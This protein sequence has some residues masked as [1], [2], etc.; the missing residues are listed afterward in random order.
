LSCLILRLGQDR[1]MMLSSTIKED[2]DLLAVD[3]TNPDIHVE[4]RLVIPRG[5]LHL[6]RTIFLWKGVCYERFQFRNYG[7][8]PIHTSFSLHFEA[9]FADIFEVRG[10]KRKARGRPFEPAME[11]GCLALAYEG[12][13]G[14]IRRT[15]IEFLPPPIAL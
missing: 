1:P 14:V 15:R 8:D 12:L 11:G 5:T 7:L 2:N 3:L 4:E 6:A 13:D 10:T 9:D